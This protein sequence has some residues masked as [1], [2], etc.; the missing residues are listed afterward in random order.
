MM[1]W[2]VITVKLEF[3]QIQGFQNKIASYKTALIA[4]IISKVN[5]WLTALPVSCLDDDI[6][7]SMNMIHLVTCLRLEILQSFKL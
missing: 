3:R 1:E 7:G 4:V 5:F 6:V 2:L